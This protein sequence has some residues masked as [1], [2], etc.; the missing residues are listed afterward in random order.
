[1]DHLAP[2]VTS[3]WLLPLDACNVSGSERER[4]GNRRRQ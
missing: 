3:L 4:E 2:V 1:M